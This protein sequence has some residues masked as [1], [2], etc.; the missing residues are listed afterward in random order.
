MLGLVH[1]AVHPSLSVGQMGTPWEINKLALYPNG[2]ASRVDSCLVTRIHSSLARVANGRANSIRS[3]FHLDSLDLLFLLVAIPLRFHDPCPV[4]VQGH[5]PS[6]SSSLAGT[7]LFTI[8]TIGRRRTNCGK[9]TVG[10]G[11]GYR[12]LFSLRFSRS[13]SAALKPYNDVR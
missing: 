3:P 10:A 8:R 13:F 5:L 1:P 4:P 12:W 11:K 6:V 7:H 9:L 2:L